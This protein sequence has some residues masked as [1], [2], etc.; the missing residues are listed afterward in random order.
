MR[1]HQ[2]YAPSS[3]SP[4]APSLRPSPPP[5]PTGSPPGVPSCFSTCVIAELLTA[6]AGP[7]GRLASD[8]R[9]SLDTTTFQNKIG[10]H[11]H[12]QLHR[13]GPGTADVQ[14]LAPIGLF[15]LPYGCLASISTTG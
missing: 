8:A 1:R 14:A 3:P 13:P 2:R 9:P 6:S 7:L 5:G 12:P 4:P 10:E 11:R 15:T